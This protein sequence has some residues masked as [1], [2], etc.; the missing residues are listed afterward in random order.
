LCGFLIGRVSSERCS[1]EDSR[2]NC[3]QI[4]SH[5]FVRVVRGLDLRPGWNLG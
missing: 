5:R 1:G 2:E 3:G 4:A